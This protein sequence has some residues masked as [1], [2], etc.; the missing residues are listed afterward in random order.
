VKFFP[1]IRFVLAAAVLV[2]AGHATDR[3][4]QNRR[5]PRSLPDFTNNINAVKFSPDGRL[6][7]IARGRRDDNRV[8][9]WDTQTGALQRTIRGF[10]GAVWSVSF[11]PDSRTLLT[12]S[13]G[14][15]QEKVSGKPSARSG[16]SFAELKW[17]D[18]QTGDFKQR[19][20]LRDDDLLA[21]AAC[22]SP[23]GRFLAAIEYRMAIMTSL[24]SRMDLSFPA[25]LSRMLPSVKYDATVKL[26]DAASGQ[27][28]FKLK[29]GFS[30]YE[31]PW[32]GGAGADL[33]FMMLGSQRRPPVVS[34][35]G[36]F[37]AAWN[38][39][40]V[41]LWNSASG[42]EVLKLKK[43]KGRL[44]AVA[45]SPD[46]KLVAAAVTRLARKHDQIEI[47][48]EVRLWEVANGTARQVIPLRTE[49]V[50]SL[51]F[52][53]NGHQL[54][55]GGLQ[56]REDRNFPS[57][58][59]IDIDGGSAGSIVS[60]DEGVASSI[61]MSPDGELMAFQTGATTV[62]VLDTQGW[63]IRYTFDAG[64]ETGHS[65]G[66]A[67]RRYLVTVKSVPAV[68]FLTDGN[69]VAG[70]V[71]G[72][73]IKL[74]DARTGEVKKA[75]AQDAQTGSIADVSA[76]GKIVA[77]LGDDA[78]RIWNIATG[79]HTEIPSE[80]SAVAVALSGDG[81]TLAVASADEVAIF[82][83]GRPAAKI[84]S[85]AA[86]LSLS[87]DG[88][89]L[90]T[91]SAGGEIQVWKTADGALQKHLPGVAGVSALRLSPQNQVLAVG[92]KDGRVTLWDLQ[93]G[94]QSFEAKKHSAMVNAI[95]FSAD[96]K[97]MATG[98]DDR[99]AII[100]EVTSGKARRT[101]KG[102]DFTVTSLAFSPGD[103]LLAVGSGNASVVLWDVVTGKLNRVMR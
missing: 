67:I 90:A 46:G 41:R 18:S 40:E 72:G 89:L 39:S 27:T 60:R 58:E 84:K 95:G 9:L 1:Q 82:N 99:S 43:F 6:L 4:A 66:A 50:S 93:S 19:F 55:V 78:L 96:G 20:E 61:E 79:E 75:L 34:P 47:H 53:S 16:R 74:W 85:N 30:D 73:G 69:T 48:S 36:Q 49:S 59:L 2:A 28:I 37:V 87:G 42:E 70:E 21:V 64:S 35:N 83:D 11:S 14:F 94:A 80:K 92:T 77:D 15:H 10:D 71:E 51:A 17:W 86:F 13:S 31:I 54:L 76:D 102:H 7:A 32:V 56:G 98:G 12:G 57:M 8:E 24:G 100:W 44:R 88:K 103:N 5:A 29:D 26:L 52:A 62:R 22:Y 25:P 38:A 81:T 97:L 3:F 65:D 91:A 101:L 68:A 45:F 63:R 33:S 23:D